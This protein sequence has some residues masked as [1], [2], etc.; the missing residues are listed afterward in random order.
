MYW[1]GSDRYQVFVE[2]HVNKANDTTRVVAFEISRTLTNKQLLVDMFVESSMNLIKALMS[3]PDDNDVR[4]KLVTRLKRHHPDFVSFNIVNPNGELIIDSHEGVKEGL[5]PDDVRSYI[6]QGERQVRLH[7]DSNT[8]HYDVISTHQAE[9]GQLLFVVSFDKSELSYILNS[10][11]PDNHD[12]MLVSKNDNNLIE[13]ASGASRATITNKVGSRMSGDEK[14][15]VLAATDVKETD[16][17]VADLR[18][19]G[20]FSDYRERV[21]SQY[22]LVFYILLIVVIFMRHIMLN[23]D[24]K[25]TEAERKLQENNEKV[26]TLNTKLDLLSKTDDLTGLYNRRHFEEKMRLEWNRGL[27]SHNA[28]S[29]ILFDVDDF[30]YYNDFYGHQA[31]DKCLKEVAT[32]L[33]DTFRRATDVVARYGGEEFIVVMAESDVEEAAT[34]IENFQGELEKLNIP[35]EA[36]VTGRVTISAGFVNG[37]P[38]RDQTLEDF[39]KQADDALYKAKDSGKNKWVNFELN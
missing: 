32:L 22:S 18:N 33:S 15:R 8:Y 38:S 26:K 27:R 31:G 21:T 12:L 9:S 30:K 29:C 19:K 35:H 2:S 1:L 36:S 23:Q 6:N 5:S 4:E 3:K 20:L 14:M 16:W 34:A 13:I 28:L 7:P 11:R 17:Y 25:R 24:K 39:V 10:M 37:T